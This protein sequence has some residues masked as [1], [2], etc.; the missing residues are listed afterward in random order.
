MTALVY[1]SV[2]L[3]M[4]T[5][6]SRSQSKKSL[7]ANGSKTS[8]SKKRS[9]KSKNDKNAC[10]RKLSA[11]LTRFLFALHAGI[12]LWRV[13]FDYP[14]SYLY[15]LAIGLVCLLFEMVFTLVVRQGKEYKW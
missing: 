10:M 5:A 7:T 3:Y 6:K 11:V 12:A 4:A 13:S 2:S 9:N 14:T 1:D 8:K 15:F